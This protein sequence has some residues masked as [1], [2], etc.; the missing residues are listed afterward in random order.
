[1]I[2][3]WDANIDCSLIYCMFDISTSFFFSWWKYFW[4]PQNA[5]KI[6]WCPIKIFIFQYRSSNLAVVKVV[7]L[8]LFAFFFVLVL[9]IDWWLYRSF[10]YSCRSFSILKTIAKSK[11]KLI[12]ITFKSEKSDNCCYCDSQKSDKCRKDIKVRIIPKLKQ[13]IIPKL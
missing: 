5:R 10:N 6:N 12:A 8:N 3:K 9:Y 7:A 1:M 4:C 2:L 11:G 13:R